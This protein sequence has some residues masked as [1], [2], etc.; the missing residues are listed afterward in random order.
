MGEKNDWT[1]TMSMFIPTHQRAKVRQRPSLV[2]SRPQ[3][4][5]RCNSIFPGV[6]LALLLHGLFSFNYVHCKLD[7]L[8]APT[9]KQSDRHRQARGLAGFSRWTST[10]Q[11]RSWNC[12]AP[13]ASAQ[14]STGSFTCDW[15]KENVKKAQCWENMKKGE[16]VASLARLSMMASANSDVSDIAERKDRDLMFFDRRFVGPKQTSGLQSAS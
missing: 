10:E 11:R 7:L 6:I 14:R 5:S 3:V 16:A 8:L 13:S 15:E 4:F 9:A 1:F 12:G 2:C